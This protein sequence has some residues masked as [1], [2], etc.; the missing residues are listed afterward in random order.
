M[1]DRQVE[2]GRR[3]VQERLN[4]AVK[5]EEAVLAALRLDEELAVISVDMKYLTGDD[6]F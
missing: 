5:L 6:M 2:A 4:A 1:V 3:P